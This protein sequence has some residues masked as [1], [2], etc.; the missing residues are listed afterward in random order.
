MCDDRARTCTAIWTGPRAYADQGASR[1]PIL[2]AQSVTIGDGYYRRWPA[3]TDG[4][5]DGRVAIR[6]AVF[7]RDSPAA[8]RGPPDGALIPFVTPLSI[9]TPQSTAKSG[10]RKVTVSVFAGPMLPRSRK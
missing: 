4:K 1:L 2:A 5:V 9:D 8:A 6:L 3:G 7:G 10:T